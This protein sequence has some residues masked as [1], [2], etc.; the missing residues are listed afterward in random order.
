MNAPGLVGTVA[1]DIAA[2]LATSGL[3]RHL[4][5]ADRRLEALGPEL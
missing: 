5:I 4:G 2:K 1:Y 3:D